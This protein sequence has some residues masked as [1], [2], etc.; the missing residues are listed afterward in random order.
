MRPDSMVAFTGMRSNA[1]ATSGLLALVTQR[2][3]RRRLEALPSERQVWPG[4]AGIVHPAPHW[5][6]ALWFENSR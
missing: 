5:A 1:K 4:I 2:F 3:A 6:K